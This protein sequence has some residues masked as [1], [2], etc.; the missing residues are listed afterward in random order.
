MTQRRPG[1]RWACPQGEEPPLG[2]RGVTGPDRFAEFSNACGRRTACAVVNARLAQVSGNACPV[3]DQ[4]SDDVERFPRA[5]GRGHYVDV[6]KEGGQAFTRLQALVGSNEGIVLA[7]RV[8][9]WGQGVALLAA[10]A[11]TDAPSGA[12]SVAP[13]VRGLLAVPQADERH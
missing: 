6:V 5:S 13:V 1:G 8:Q 3:L 11:L 12:R 4:R 7:K 10:F 2:F 9:G